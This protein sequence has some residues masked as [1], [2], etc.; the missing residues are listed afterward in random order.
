MGLRVSK[1][2]REMRQG[3]CQRKKLREGGG[4]QSLEESPN[5]EGDGFE[6]FH[7]SENWSAAESSSHGWT[8]ERC[9]EASRPARTCGE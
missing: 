9:T 2:S 7:E 8:S 1:V 6:V 3:W 4:G 5:G